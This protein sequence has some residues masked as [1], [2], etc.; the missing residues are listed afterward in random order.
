[1]STCKSCGASIIWLRTPNRKWMPAN[2]GLVP[3]KQCEDGKDYV[4]DDLGNL[5]RCNIL[6]KD[7]LP[8]GQ[9]PTGLARIPHWATCP[10]AAKFKRGKDG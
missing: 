3:Y 8:P 9:F 4:V 7:E 10:A 2:E 1:M 5:I 6:E